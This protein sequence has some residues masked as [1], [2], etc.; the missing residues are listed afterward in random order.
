MRFPLRSRNGGTSKGVKYTYA[1]A[2]TLD[3][4][5]NHKY[6]H[7]GLGTRQVVGLL[8]GIG[9]ALICVCHCGNDLSKV[10]G[11]GWPMKEQGG[12]IVRGHDVGGGGVGSQYLPA[13]IRGIQDGHCCA[14]DE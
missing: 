10:R 3:T 5:T 4:V 9:T 7:M 14:H 12:A 8:V 13:P 6:N 1:Y 2:G 11:S